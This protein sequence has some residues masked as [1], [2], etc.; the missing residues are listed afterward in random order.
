MPDKC[1][2]IIDE[3][4]A[5]RKAKGLTQRELAKATNLAQSA[6][7]R[8]ESKTIVP[9]LDTLLN[10]AAALDCRLELVPMF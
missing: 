3:L 10:I 1:I 4:I 5:L 2:A 9:Q 7:A 8:L 6:I